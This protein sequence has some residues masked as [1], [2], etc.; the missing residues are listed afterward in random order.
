MGLWE[1]GQRA[2]DTWR[3]RQVLWLWKMAWR[4][5]GFHSVLQNGTDY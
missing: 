1:S 2:V 5:P 3:V 4:D